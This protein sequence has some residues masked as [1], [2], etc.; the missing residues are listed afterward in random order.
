MG[1]YWKEM[2]ATFVKERAQHQ[3]NIENLQNDVDERNVVK[4]PRDRQQA[5]SRIQLG[6]VFRV[7]KLA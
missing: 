3:E 4:Q 5:W 6:M 7:Q 2:R 1:K